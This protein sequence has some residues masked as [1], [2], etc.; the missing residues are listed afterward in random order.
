M[1]LACRRFAGLGRGDFRARG[2]KAGLD[3]IGLIDDRQALGQIGVVREVS[4]AVP[5]REHSRHQFEAEACGRCPG[6]F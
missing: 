2:L 1:A 5:D 3:K 4:V 6:E